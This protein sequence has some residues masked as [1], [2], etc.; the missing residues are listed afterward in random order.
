LTDA[1]DR[2]SHGTH[3]TGIIAGNATVGEADADGYRYG[4]GVA[5]G[6]EIVTQRLFDGIGAYHAPPT[7]ETMTRH[8]V[9]AGAEIGSN[10]WGDDVQG[11]YDLF[12]AEFDALVRDAD[13]LTPG[14]QPYILEF[15]A[16]NSGPGPQTIGTPA[17][18]KNVIAT[19]A[20][21]NDRFDFFI[22]DSGS[23]TMADF[24]SRGPCEDGRIKPDVVA[25]G[26]WIAS[27]RSSLANDDNA[28]A[29]ISHYYL[30]QGGTSQSG[31]HVSGAAAIFVQ[32]YRETVTNATPSPA[33]VKAALINSAIDID[34]GYSTGPIPN[35]DE[36]WGR[37]NLV[38]LIDSTKKYE[39]VDQTIA[40]TSGQTFERNVLVASA[41][42]P[43][44]I[45]MVYTDVPGFP[46][47]V[48]ALV[49]D[50]DLEV[51]A[52]NGAV[53]RGNQFEYGESVMNAPSFDN[54]N[55]VEAVHLLAPVP[56]EYRV[57][58]HARNV[59]EDARLDTA[60]VDQDFA[61]VISADIPLPGAGILFFDKKNYNAPSTARLKL[62]DFDLA[63]QPSVNVVVRSSTE[64]AGETYTLFAENSSGA[65]TNGIP[66]VTGSPVQ[67]GKLQI[68]HG[69]LLQAF[70][71]DASPAGTRV[72]S[73]RADL[74]APVIS[75]VSVTNR[76]GRTL[77]SWN[78]DEPA[79]SI[80]YFG[81][82]S[83][84]SLSTANSK[85]THSHEVALENLVV[86]Q[87]YQF[88]VSSADE[89][90][91]RATNNN[92]GSYFSFV[93]ERA[94]VILLVD[95][96]TDPFFSVPPLTGY[97][98]ALSQVGVSFEVWHVPTNGSPTLNDL[99]PFQAVIWRVPEFFGSFSP[100]ERTAVTAY[101]EQGGGFLLSTMD[102]LTRLGES[103]GASFRTNVLRVLDFAEDVGASDVFGF[104]NDPITSGIDIS[105]DYS[106]YEDPWKELLGIPE[107]I[108]D[109]LVIAP[110]AS[111]ILFESSGKV[112][113]LR[114]PRIGQDSNGRVVFLS[115]PLD[116]VPLHGAAPNNRV[117]LLRNIISFLVPGV[118]GIGTIAL[119]SPAY[120][121]PSLATVEVADSDLAG[122]SQL[123]VTIF[124]DTEPA[125]QTIVLNETVRP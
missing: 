58:V 43:L 1:S 47:A 106:P 21:E 114:Y 88:F 68:T 99:R 81:T 22:Y 121:I 2:H 78:T 124:S 112:V 61:L 96:Y 36:G 9:Q 54:I 35:N 100:G 83:L 116:A 29:P 105:L 62:I 104:N 103:G 110:E 69:D 24:S 19:G 115:F 84:F 27:L 123:T 44:R 42:E 72:A 63:G 7:F 55:N 118:N 101:L 20:T 39:F 80:V 49:N 13:A 12:A 50:M 117:N 95:S 16:G 46:A 8:A 113:G 73:A 37:V 31:P 92:G 32:Y 14:D 71:Q 65:F 56:G 93:A 76:Y 45:T 111:P 3:V 5:P 4:L 108:S 86:G 34:D 64:S 48:R 107:D 40:L 33:L 77:V 11:R 67:D 59:P 51:I 52:P 70:Y 60:Q 102:G 17:L 15:S 98:D 97:T 30:Y 41:D 18:A 26:T 91:N 74:V 120:T 25:P 119:D 122:T 89:A 6:V 125:G 10:S 75:N 90:G 57:R 53:Y 87:T 94:A 79:D 82:N 66:L 109:T 28:W 85:L 23:E 38:E